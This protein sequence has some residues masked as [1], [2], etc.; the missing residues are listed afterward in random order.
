MRDC[1]VNT[2]YFDQNSKFCVMCPPSNPYFN[3][4][5]NLCQSCGTLGYDETLRR[6]KTNDVSV[7]PTL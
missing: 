7:D 5:T 3:L 2:P 4:H 6:C 1:P